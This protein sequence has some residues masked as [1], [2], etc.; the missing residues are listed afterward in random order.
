MELKNFFAQ[1]EQGNKLPEAICY[2]YQR[3]TESLAV[4]LKAATGVAIG[5]PFSTDVNGRIEFAAPDGLYDL[6]VV[7]ANRDYRFPVQCLDVT[8][9]VATAQAAADRAQLA[10]DAAWLSAGLY[11]NTAAGLAATLNGEYFSV[12]V[13]GSDDFLILYRKE[14]GAA[15]EQARYASAAATQ[16]VANTAKRGNYQVLGRT[17]KVE[18]VAAGFDHL[19]SWSRLYVFRAA[20]SLPAYVQP[21]TDLYVPDGH[22]AYVDLN[23]APV[24]NEY[25]VHVSAVTLGSI[26]N[27][28]GTYI[29]DGKLILFTCLN[30]ILGGALDPQYHMAAPGTVQR[31]ALAD[32][33]RNV[34]DRAGWH[35]VGKATKMQPLASTPSTY[36]VS[37]PE[38]L[39]TGGLT[40][41]SKRVAPVSSVSV[42]SGE[43]IYVDLDSAP[44]ES[45]QLVPQVTSGGF[46]VGMVTSGT[47]VSDRKV[48]LFINSTTGIG[49]PLAQQVITTDFVDTTLNNRGNRASYQL[50]GDLSK[51]LLSGTNCVMSFGDLR[52]TRGVGNSTLVVAG[53]ADV[54]VPRGQALYVDLSA[55]LVGG[56]LVPQLTTSGYS[57][58]GGGIASGAFVNDS[59]LYL[60]INDALG[61]AGALANRRPAN[62][63]LGEVW[64]KTSPSNIIFDPTTRTLSWDNFLIL[65]TIGGQGRIRLAPGSYTFANNTYNVAYLDLSVAVTTGDTPATAVKGG[66]YHDGTIAER[67]RGQA[68]QLPLFYWNGVSDFGSLGGFPRASEPGAT[69]V[70]TLAVDDVVV[71]VGLNTLSAFVKGAKSSSKKYLEQTIGYENKPFD[72]TG[73]DAYGNSDLWRLKHGYECD[74]DFSTMAF[75]RARAGQA[76]LNGGEI[77]G[78]WKEQGAVDYFGGYH[79][80]EIKTHAAL[81]LDGVQIPFN[82]VATYVG[83]KLELV[84]YS[85]LYKCNTQIEVATHAKRVSITHDHGSMKIELSQQV[86]WSK[87]LVLEA[88]MMTMLPIKRLL[89]DTSGDVITNTAMRAPYAST[90]DVSATGFPQ[91]ATLGKL[92]ASKLWGP[93]GISASVEI[94][95]HPGHADCGF[96]VANASFYNKLYYSVAGSTVSTMG[97]VN[98]TTQPGEAWDVESVIRMTTSN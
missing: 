24:N 1:D 4:G 30:G 41:T 14:A 45:G 83:K 22:C 32:A 43:A 96:Y 97:G 65:P 73:T 85:K 88:A 63:Y 20:G 75:T 47:F 34:T 56:M 53:M 91:V 21:V 95:K 25:L 58:A 28:A 70:S 69:A 39:V 16:K 55:D 3:G 61:F 44:N 23:E 15:K 40:T 48:Y 76:L 78:A 74:V 7:K 59:K 36:S 10:R 17:S 12:P 60:F 26:D 68:H 82:T 31:S 67:Y 6:R 42:A 46:T 18:K 19:V 33:I 57:S 89:A 49:G 98:H 37:F 52:I 64:L 35:V 5:N 79:G 66:T 72:P 50:I 11:P 71:K 90:E 80:D 77:E 8:A 93:T 81:F 51:F 38:L 13:T 2:V 29:E 84:Q 86:E 27:P 92:P 9:N 87:S 54:T 94:L 62:A